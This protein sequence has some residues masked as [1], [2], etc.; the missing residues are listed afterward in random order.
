MWITLCLSEKDL[1]SIMVGF[2]RVGA[3]RGGRDLPHLHSIMVGFNPKDGGYG[4]EV[5]SI[6]IPLWSD[7]ITRTYDYQIK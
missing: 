6:Y 2:N 3:G 7:S 1:H 5:M 4:F